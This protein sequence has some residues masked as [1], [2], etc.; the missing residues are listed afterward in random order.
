MPL[1]ASAVYG[2]VKG[3][4]KFHGLIGIEKAEF[5]PNIPK[6]RMET[7]PFREI[8]MDFGFVE[9]VLVILH[10]LPVLDHRVHLLVVL[11]LCVGHRRFITTRGRVWWLA[12][13]ATKRAAHFELYVNSFLGIY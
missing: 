4:E 11:V 8:K 1:P 12:Y 3:Q 13:M 5:L 7:V 9:K 2:R 6:F 10:G